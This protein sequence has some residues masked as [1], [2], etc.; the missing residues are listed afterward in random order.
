[1]INGLSATPRIIAILLGIAIPS[2]V[3]GRAVFAVIV[4]L[5]LIALFF[6][7]PWRQ[8]AGDLWEQCQRPLGILILLTFVAWLPN[9]GISN[10][11]L[12]SFEAVFRTLAFVGIAAVFFAYMSSDQ[13]LTTTCF[14]VFMASAVV[15][16]GFAFITMTVLPELFWFLRLKGW[17]STSIGFSHKG[18]SAL[19]VMIIPLAV[20]GAYRIG[21]VWKVLG[22]VICIGMLA[23]VWENYNR[24]T[25]AGFLAMAISVAVAW[26]IGRGGKR[27]VLIT[28]GSV[29]ALSAVVF[30]WLKITRQQYEAFAPNTD[31]LVPVWL[32]DYERQTI[33]MAAWEFGS[34]SPWF[35]IGANAINFVPGADAIIQGTRDLHIIPAHPHNW[36]VEI[37]AETGWVGLTALLLT[38]SV[39]SFQLIKNYRQFNS[40]GILAAIAIMA[41]YWGSGLFNFSYWSAW[42][43][44]SF[45]LSV[46]LCL[47]SDGR[48]QS[49]RAGRH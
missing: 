10:Y 22:A 48:V 47:A 32:V 25:I 13:R 4:G 38:V 30:T 17:Q 11:P 40:P 39:M 42:W 21:G 31:W 3:F 5:A 35:G 23:L 49:D 15:G 1:M 9:V 45:G 24:S 12:R 29:G 28:I 2:V 43:Q 6:C 46:V 26:T 20:L 18:F 8:I 41:G 27:Q 33:W 44:L 16:T 19:A 34:E 14:Q 7:K 36:I 37:Y